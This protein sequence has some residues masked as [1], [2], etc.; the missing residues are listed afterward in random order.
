MILVAVFYDIEDDRVR[1][2]VAEFLL[3]WGLER[4]QYSGFMGYV[5]ETALERIKEGVEKMLDWNDRAHVFVLG[6]CSRVITLAAAENVED[7][8]VFVL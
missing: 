3:N 5:P 1:N 7:E 8:D 2:R 6:N 4:I